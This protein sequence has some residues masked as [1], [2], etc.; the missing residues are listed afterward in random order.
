MTKIIKKI[1]KR[2]TTTLQQKAEKKEQ[3]IQA[4]YAQ[5]TISPTCMANQ[6]NPKPRKKT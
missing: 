2:I 6:K 4:K 3:D 1:K 5:G